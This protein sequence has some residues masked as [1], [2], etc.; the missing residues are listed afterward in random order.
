[1][2]SLAL[3][4]PWMAGAGE[5]PVGPWGHGHLE[6]RSADSI[7]R[8]FRRSCPSGSPGILSARCNPRHGWNGWQRRRCALHTRV[9]ERPMRTLCITEYYSQGT[10]DD[11]GPSTYHH[12]P[13]PETRVPVWPLPAGKAWHL[14]PSYC[15]KIRRAKSKAKSRWKSTTTTCNTK[16]TASPRFV[17]VVHVFPS[18]LV[19]QVLA[20]LPPRPPI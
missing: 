6:G 5:S 10:M 16:P 7:V 19:G 4:S 1:M 20:R 3:H 11:H 14:M 8:S 12:W 9:R 18:P 15:E 17:L 2:D 13:L